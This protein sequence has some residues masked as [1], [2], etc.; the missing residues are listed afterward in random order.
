MCEL[1][2]DLLI[3]FRI[4]F[5]SKGLGRPGEG[6]PKEATG[7]G[8]TESKRSDRSWGG[9][10]NPRHF[11]LHSDSLSTSISLAT[12]RWRRGQF[13]LWHLW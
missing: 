1:A 3:L 5:A 4:L 9:L 6:L 11:T 7:D 12:G 2:H 10:V 13:L 8:G